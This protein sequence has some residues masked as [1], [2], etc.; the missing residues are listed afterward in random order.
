M[1]PKVGGKWQGE[2]LKMKM[3]GGY[4]SNLIGEGPK[5]ILSIKNEEQISN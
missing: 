2:G 5:K 1:T 3:K 4:F